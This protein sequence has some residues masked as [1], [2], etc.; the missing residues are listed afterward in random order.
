MGRTK[1]TIQEQ[2]ALLYANDWLSAST[3]SVNVQLALFNGQASLFL[4]VEVKFSIDASGAMTSSIG[5]RVL[6][7]R[8][9]QNAW[10]WVGDI[11]LWF[12]IMCLGFKQAAS[13]CEAWKRR[14]L[15]QH[16]NVY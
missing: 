4:F 5:L 6:P 9:Y 11:L 7:A 13:F 10:C 3:S 16:F 14:K 8:V 12:L 15:R 2:L 1:T